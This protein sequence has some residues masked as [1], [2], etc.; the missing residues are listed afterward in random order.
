LQPH[1]THSHSKNFG[2]RYSKWIVILQEFDLEFERAK[3]K[4][5]LVFTELICD[6]PSIETETVAKDSL[7]NESIFFIISYDIWYGDIIIYL[8]NQ[9]LRHDL[10]STDRH[11]IQYQSYQYIILGDTL[12]HHG[13]DSI[14]RRCL[15]Y[16]EDE[17]YL[18]ECH[19]RACGD[20]MNGYAIAQKIL[21]SGYFWPSLFKD[22]ITVV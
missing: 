2:G 6:L 20:H 11:H 10:S 15:T 8:P 9:N 7:P 4:K 19:S 16:D 14:F 13:I 18:N 12:Y 3:S 1:A 5:S 17:K 21:R 22:C